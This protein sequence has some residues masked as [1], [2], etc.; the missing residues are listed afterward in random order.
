MLSPSSSAG[1]NKDVLANEIE[2]LF[3]NIIED[4]IG[5]V[6]FL[7]AARGIVRIIGMYLTYLYS[8]WYITY[9]KIK[10]LKKYTINFRKTWQSVCSN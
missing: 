5:T 1:D 8:Q 6:E 9:T 10:D 2:V 4:K 7:D 3:P